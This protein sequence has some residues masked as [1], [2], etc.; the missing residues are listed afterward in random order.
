MVGCFVRY[1]VELVIPK[2]DTRRSSVFEIRSIYNVNK[3]EAYY[4]FVYLI[5]YELCANAYFN[6]IM[7]G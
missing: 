3:I 6:L 4:T 2:L 7:Q 5:R 1:S